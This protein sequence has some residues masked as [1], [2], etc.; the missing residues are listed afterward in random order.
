MS[1]DGS[2]S[3]CENSG[4]IFEQF[5]LFSAPRL[6]P[7]LLRHID[8]T[9]KD[10]RQTT[11]SV[12]ALTSKSLCLLSE[13]LYKT[14]KQIYIFAFKYDET[15]YWVTIMHVFSDIL[16]ITSILLYCY[17]FYFII[18]LNLI[19]KTSHVPIKILKNE[20]GNR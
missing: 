13:K 11:Q 5:Q 12:H 9:V 15:V 19:I 18:E 17:N 3:P 7:R 14:V 6:S 4:Y 10:Y 8:F 1:Y 16:K 20:R 2:F